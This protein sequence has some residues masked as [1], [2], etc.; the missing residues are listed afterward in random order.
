[1]NIW[2]LVS[3]EVRNVLY[4]M[5]IRFS[6]AYLMNIYFR[7]T[8][9]TYWL[10]GA[11]RT[12]GLFALCAL[13]A[14]S[15]DSQTTALTVLMAVAVATPG[16]HCENL[17]AEARVLLFSRRRHR[18]PSLW[19]VSASYGLDWWWYPHGTASPL[20]TTGELTYLCGFSSTSKVQ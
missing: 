17:A 6:F 2:Y 15:I 10:V 4:D 14:R 11:L 3:A 5:L 18:R 13:Q 19:V 12:E 16:V 9:I 1:V 8:Y 7:N 20:S